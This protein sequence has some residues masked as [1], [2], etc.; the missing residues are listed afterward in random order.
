[1]G[2]VDV[3]IDE[4]HH[5]F[6]LV[7]EA[8]REYGRLSTAAAQLLGHGIFQLRKAE[9]LGKLGQSRVDPFGQLGITG[10]DQD[11]QVRAFYLQDRRQ[12][13][14]GHHGHSVVDDDQ[15]DVRCLVPTEQPIALAASS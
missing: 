6:E 4:A 10:D 14:A 11:R 13:R 1:M 9:R 12:F 15:I 3:R 8:R 7:M 2:F 5:A